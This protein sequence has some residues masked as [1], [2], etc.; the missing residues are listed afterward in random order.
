MPN[1]L[2]L[3]SPELIPF[4]TKYLPIQD[5]KKCYS[6]DDIWKAEAIREICKRLIVDCL[7]IN[8]KTTIKALIDP[9]FQY[10]SISKALA[11]KMYLYIFREWGSRYPVV[12]KL[13]VGATNTGK[14]VM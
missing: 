1:L 9:K 5:L 10:I 3:L 12:E 7:F 6:L 2:N 11:K 8:S 13:G 14:N 4:I